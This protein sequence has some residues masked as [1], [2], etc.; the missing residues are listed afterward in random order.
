MFFENE[1]GVGMVVFMLTLLYL[2]TAS[3]ACPGPEGSGTSILSER[4]GRGRGR[5]ELGGGEREKR[6]GSEGREGQE[7][8]LW[9]TFYR[10]TRSGRER[11]S[12][13]QLVQG[14]RRVAAAI[15]DSRAP[16]LAVASQPRCLLSSLP[17]SNL[18]PL[19]NHGISSS[20]TNLLPP[21][22]SRKPSPVS[23]SHPSRVRSRRSTCLSPRS[24]RL[25]RQ[26]GRRSQ[27]VAAAR[28]L[29]VH[30]RDKVGREAVQRSCGGRRSRIGRGQAMLQHQLGQCS[31]LFIYTLLCTRETG[32]P[33]QGHGVGCAVRRDHALRC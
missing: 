25:H 6:E 20:S 33:R 5:A 3:T 7:W 13:V 12:V 8:T 1:Q 11:R 29:R 24:S 30:R 28:Q 22:P 32:P 15:F 26:L 4:R 23:I 19:S 21:G 17:P 2:L 31:S 18:S 9:V 27:T 16:S 10:E 14:R